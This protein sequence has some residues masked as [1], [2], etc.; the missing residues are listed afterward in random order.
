WVL[1]TPPIPC[2]AWTTALSPANSRSRS[3]A[4]RS[5]RPVNPGL[6]AGMFHTGGP[7]PGSRGMATGIGDGW[8]TT[9]SML[10]WMYLLCWVACSPIRTPGPPAPP[11]R[12]G[13][14][15]AP[16]LPVF[17]ARLLGSG[18]ARAE[19]VGLRVVVTDLHALGAVDRDQVL[20]RPRPRLIHQAHQRL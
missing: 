3:S 18:R 11:P 1:P 13:G 19:G 4:S 20:P 5:S 10:V 9:V 15:S 7:L 14:S 12:V 17:P 16:V 8:I 2:S 6:R